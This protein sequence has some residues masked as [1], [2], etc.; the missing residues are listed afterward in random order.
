MVFSC[1]KRSRWP[2]TSIGQVADLV[3]KQRAA[4]RGLDAADLLLDG[5]GEGAALV[6]E[7]LRFDDAGGQARAI[8]GDE[9][10]L[11]ELRAIVDGA[12]RQLLAGAGLAGDEHGGVDLGE[13][14][15]L[16]EDAGERG[17]GA[18]HVGIAL[19]GGGHDV[20]GAQV[21]VLERDQAGDVAEAEHQA[22]AADRQAVEIVDQ[23]LGD[24]GRQLG[25]TRQ[26]GI[27][28][29]DQTQPRRIFHERRRALQGGG[30]DAGAEIE[31]AGDRAQAIDLLA[32]LLDR[33]AGR[34][35][36]CA[37]P[38]GPAA[39]QQDLWTCR[40]GPRRPRTVR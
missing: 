3:E 14:A 33:P 13:L 5:A 30:I 15:D 23:A 22:F 8:D 27:D 38:P 10:A 21:A 32:R 12:R 25:R 2:W 29:R 19:V 40:S 11:V 31:Q 7:Q 39:G 16:L 1:R 9:G 18:D 17:A 20:G 35:G 6:A 28:E 34:R 36:G 26:R 24:Q 4:A 37:R